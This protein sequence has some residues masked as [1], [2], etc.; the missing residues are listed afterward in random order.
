MPDTY[1]EEQVDEMIQEAVAKT[2][3]SFAGT[4]K[5]LKEKNEKLV[6]VEDAKRFQK[7]LEEEVKAKIISFEEQTGLVVDS[8]CLDYIHLGSMANPDLKRLNSVKIHVC[9]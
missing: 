4:I 2:E 5:R 6:T 8:I 3:K 7:I 1:S 9:L